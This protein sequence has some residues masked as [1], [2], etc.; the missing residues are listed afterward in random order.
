MHET[1]SCGGCNAGP[2]P[3]AERAASAAPVF[4]DG[5]EIAEEAI[6]AEAQNHT[7]ATGAEARA[8]AAR[9]LVIRHLLLSRA[10]A[11]GID[12]KPETDEAGRREIDEEALIRQVMEREV[13]PV[14]PDRDTCYRY[15]RTHGLAFTAPALFEA[16]HILFAAKP[17]IA[18]AVA[19]ATA[20]ITGIGD[21]ETAFRA[22]ARSASACPSGAVGGSLGQ[23]RPGDLA[24]EI[25][26]VLIAL[27]PGHVAASPVVSH[28]G[29]HVVRLDRSVPARAIPFE[30]VEPRI[31]DRLAARAWTTAAARYVAGLA[32]DA[33]ID[34][35]TLEVA[36]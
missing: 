26:T 5:V 14:E 6:A 18:T 30:A 8:A 33:R 7:A 10:A 28:F 36:A 13:E 32:R 16:S 3:A 20:A 11:L 25:E 1:S 34:G 24:R 35:I 4:V 23:V 31:R 2:R 19:R 27:A 29:A 15:W 12:A 22:L 21:S 9:A 17:D